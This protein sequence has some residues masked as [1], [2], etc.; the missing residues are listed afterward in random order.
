MTIPLP[1]KIKEKQTNPRLGPTHVRG[2][3]EYLYV[4]PKRD[5]WMR[6][7]ETKH[8]SKFISCDQ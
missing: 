8:L 1:N 6:K 3:E 4:C 5:G 2:R 7:V